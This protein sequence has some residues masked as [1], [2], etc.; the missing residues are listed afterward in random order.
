MFVVRSMDTLGYLMARHG[1]ALDRPLSTVY[2]MKY[3]VPD[4]GI[5]KTFHT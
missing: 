3:S 5:P 1:V 2:L 4:G